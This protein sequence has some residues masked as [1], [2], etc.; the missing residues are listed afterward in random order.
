MVKKLSGLVPVAVVAEALCISNNDVMGMINM[1]KLKGYPAGADKWL[2]PAA[3]INEML[4]PTPIQDGYPV[5]DAVSSAKGDDA[6]K[7]VPNKDGW[8]Q[9]KDGIFKKEVG[10]KDYAYKY[11]IC[12][13]DATGKKIDRTRTLNDERKPF[14]T[15][16]EAEAH[17]NALIKE[18]LEKTEKQSNQETIEQIFESYILNRSSELQPGTISK[19]IGNAKKHIIPYFE[20]RNINDISVGEVKNFAIRKHEVLSY[21]TVKGILQTARA[22]WKYGYEMGIVS[23]EKY[24]DIFID[25]LTKVEIKRTPKEI[26]AKQKPVETFETFELEEFNKLSLEYGGVSQSLCKPPN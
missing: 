22:I 3:M 24:V 26:A 10:K 13:Y 8:V 20:D 9:V 11:R 14:K 12:Q 19:H 17:R 18:L 5:K 15:V 21:E 1:G 16:R 2:V 4:N 23:K 6:M 7:K 25:D